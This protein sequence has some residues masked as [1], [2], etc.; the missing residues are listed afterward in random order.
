MCYDC[1]KLCFSCCHG[2]AAVSHCT[3]TADEEDAG[4]SLCIIVF[5]GATV[6]PNLGDPATVIA[7]KTNYFLWNKVVQEYIQVKRKGS[8]LVFIHTS[9]NNRFVLVPVNDEFH[10]SLEMWWSQKRMHHH[11]NNHIQGCKVCQKRLGWIL[12]LCVSTSCLLLIMAICNIFI[13]T[14]WSIFR[15]PWTCITAV[16]LRIRLY[17]ECYSPLSEHLLLEQLIKVTKYT[18]CIV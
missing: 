17:F 16:N 13:P 7:N 15:S 11:T 10:L 1:P 2:A 14:E 18:T 12:F 5:L 4:D 3:S 9:M 6:T 8:V